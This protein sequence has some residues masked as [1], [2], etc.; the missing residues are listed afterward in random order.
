[1][2]ALALFLVITS[3]FMHAGWNLV[4]RH[5]RA[6]AAALIRRAL[7]VVAVAGLVP[8]VV[9]EVLWGPLPLRAWLYVVGSGVFVAVY[10]LGL[11]RGYGARDFTV[12]YPVV[13]ALPVLLVGLGDV[14]RGRLPTAAGWVG[15]V[16]VSAGCLLAPRTSFR[17]FHLRDYLQH[18]SLWMLIAALGT[19]GYTM[20]DKMA[21]EV[22]PE[23]PLSAARYGYLF[24]VMSLV[25][26]TLLL[27]VFGVGPQEQEEG[28]PV[29]WRLPVWC[30]VLN[31][32]AYWLVLWAYQL[33]QRASYVVA[34]RQVS[35]VI[36]VVAA[37]TL[38]RER[39]V[40]VRMTAV[41]L[42]TAGLVVIGVW[43]R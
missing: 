21:S 7:L 16:L 4:A 14:L 12:V 33:A 8:A 13:R 6:A 5:R 18:S 41:A 38:F 20:L 19:V 1:M 9:S 43:G 35:I 24:F 28:R 32:G 3:T 39:G 26:L 15:M 36:G 22:V 42:I 17:K 11:T 10:Y 34:F 27:R 40:V 30:G 29:G 25:F 31:F 2:N 23:G 37:F